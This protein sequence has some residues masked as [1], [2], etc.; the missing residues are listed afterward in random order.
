MGSCARRGVFISVHSMS[1]HKKQHFIPACYLKAWC[2]PLT[3]DNQTPYVWMFSKNGNIAKNKSPENIFTETDI[4][5]I[6]SPDGKRDLV[7]EHGLNQLE[8]EFVKIRRTK[9]GKLSSLD[10]V[11]N[12][13]IC[14]F[15]GAMKVRTPAMRDHHKKQWGEAL[16][17]MD[18]MKE[19]AKTATVEEKI[20][21]SSISSG[22]SG[23]GFNYEQVKSMHENP[24]QETLLPMIGTM[25][26]LLSKL[27]FAVLCSKDEVGFV[28][29]D[30]PCVW[31]DPQAYKRP[32]LYQSPGLWSKTI[33]ITLPISPAQ[34]L[35]LSRGGLTGKITVD[36][37][38]VDQLNRR[39]I[40]YS[41]EHF[42]VRSKI[43]R[44]SWFKVDPEPE[45]SWENT[46]KRK[47]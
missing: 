17:M 43:K 19:W 23:K 7:F 41:K 46:Q 10:V 36:Q 27:D 35:I 8:T 15:I 34:C 13:K 20:Q 37:N 28:T 9:L 6:K 5:T 25:T 4:Y 3:P 32:P 22:G 16:E 42:I 18:D 11:E 21:A 30:D 33:E 39:A 31:Y 44:E 2:D 12:M 47:N 29:S 14:A 45:D 1:K 26:H 40:F 24:L 38:I